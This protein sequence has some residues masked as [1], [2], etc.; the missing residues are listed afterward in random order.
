[1]AHLANRERVERS[2]EGGGNLGRDLD[3]APGEPDHDEVGGPFGRDC[4]GKATPGVAAIVKQGSSVHA[5]PGG[6]ARG[7]TAASVFSLSFS[8]ANYG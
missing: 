8:A 1:M 4:V 3:A 7:S 2:V 5:G 6:S